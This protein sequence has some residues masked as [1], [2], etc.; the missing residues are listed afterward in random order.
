MSIPVENLLTPES[1]R[2]VAWAP[3]EPTDRASIKAVLESL[4]ARTWQLEATAQVVADA[5][6]E[7]S[8]TVEDPPEIAS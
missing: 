2:R 8:Q 6:V 5:F 1:L 7:A 4:G 3:P